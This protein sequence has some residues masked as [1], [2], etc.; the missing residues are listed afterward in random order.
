MIEEIHRKM[1][2]F[3]HKAYGFCTL[4]FVAAR[5]ILATQQ[6]SPLGSFLR[7]QESY[8][9][10]PQ[11]VRDDNLSAIA[12]LFRKDAVYIFYDYSAPEIISEF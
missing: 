3:A 7:R 4:I 6:S 9:K 1:L 8:L 12:A 10:I 5:S 11:Q 2:L